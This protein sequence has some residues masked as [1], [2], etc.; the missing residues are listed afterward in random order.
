MRTFA[1]PT[2]K[3]D[4]HT[5]WKRVAAMLTDDAVDDYLG[6]DPSMVPFTKVTG[7]AALLASTDESDGFWLQK[8]AVPTDAG[9]YQVLVQRVTPGLSDRLLVVELVEP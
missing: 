5:W 6:T 1:R 4:P 9:T 2:G 3:L 7:P 8:V